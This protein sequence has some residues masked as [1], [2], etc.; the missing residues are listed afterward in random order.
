MIETF[1]DA[2]IPIPWGNVGVKTWSHAHLNMHIPWIFVEYHVG[3]DD[4][5]V[6][7]MYILFNAEQLMQLADD[8]TMKI[9]NAYLVTPGYMNKSMRWQMDLLKSVS[10]G[11]EKGENQQLNRFQLEDAAEYFY[12]NVKI[13]GSFIKEQDVY[14]AS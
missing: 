6:S 14:I 11:Y 4:E 7:G 3:K 8:P 5:Q 13:K 12:P 10:I 2:E 1:T 9:V